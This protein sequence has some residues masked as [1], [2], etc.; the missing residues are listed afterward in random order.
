MLE[1]VKQKA[2]SGFNAAKSAVGIQT[3]Q[4]QIDE[5][6]EFC[7]NLTWNQRIYGFAACYVIGY[8]IT[9]MS[10]NFFTDLIDGDPVPF[11]VIYSK[12]TSIWR[13][14]LYIYMC[15]NTWNSITHHYSTTGLGNIVSLCSA[16]FLCGPKRQF[17]RMFDDTRRTV[18]I[19]YL[20]TLAASIILCLIKF[21]KD[22]KLGILIVLLITQFFSSIWYSLSYIPLAR[23]A[24]K[25][26][27]RQ[28]TD[29]IV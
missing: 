16:M 21:D 22:A 3:E 12:C 19:I 1:S 10:F 27:F 8:L 24:V 23:R 18:T 14:R 25:K 26:F 28:Q 7:P 9:F 13:R 5:I 6:A 11:V 20:T 15:F 2:S 4:S 29:D 17:K